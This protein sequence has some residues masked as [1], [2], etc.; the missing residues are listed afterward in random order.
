MVGRVA[1]A[2]SLA[3]GAIDRFY[4]RCVEGRLLRQTDAGREAGR[5][6]SH[7]RSY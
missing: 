5:D 4:R 6:D 7:D 2:G 3:A 1:L